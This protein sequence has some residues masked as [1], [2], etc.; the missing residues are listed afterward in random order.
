[1]FSRG[2]TANNVLLEDGLGSIFFD[3]KPRVEAEQRWK[4]VTT[5]GASADGL[6]WVALPFKKVAEDN[7]APMARFDPVLGKY[8]VYVRRWLPCW[9]GVPTRPVR[10]G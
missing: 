9:P 5:Q 1:M 4:M 2:S 8:V 3:L 6:R 7:T 10:S